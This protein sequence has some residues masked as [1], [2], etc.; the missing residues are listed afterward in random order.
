MLN[1]EK[2]GE[3]K[4]KPNTLRMAITCDN[5]KR[6][7]NTRHMTSMCSFM[8]NQNKLSKR[9]YGIVKESSRK[10][11]TVKAQWAMEIKSFALMMAID[12]LTICMYP[13]SK[14]T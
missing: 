5:G 3:E 9:K 6:K 4:K 7:K 1:V 2:N 14:Y 10:T 13:R 11:H 12:T 8:E